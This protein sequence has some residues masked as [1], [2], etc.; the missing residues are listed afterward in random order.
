[1]KDEYLCLELDC[2]AVKGKSEGVNIYT[3]VDNTGIN[4]NYARTHADF[5]I[6]Y[7]SQEWDKLENYFDVLK[8]AFNGE[9]KDYYQ[10]MKERVEGYKTTSQ[11]IGTVFLG[12]IQNDII[13][14]TLLQ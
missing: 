2:L 3:I 14:Y 8:T 10:M 13:Y 12:Q 4:R 6:Y 5:L 7:R 1:V 9:M 11:K